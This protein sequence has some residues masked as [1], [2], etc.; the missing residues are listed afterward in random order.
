MEERMFK[1]LFFGFCITM[2][3][4]AIGHVLSIGEK[5]REKTFIYYTKKL[6]KAASQNDQRSSYTMLR[7]LKKMLRH[8]YLAVEIE[9][10]F[11]EKHRP[12]GCST[13]DEQYQLYAT[14]WKLT[15]NRQLFTPKELKRI[16]KIN[17][18]ADLSAQ[19]KKVK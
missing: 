11:F 17:K 6:Q 14:V 7:I 15:E 1:I 9:T 19:E 18:I 10:I 16:D 3:L 13:S 2:I 5:V 4:M 8:T 12:M